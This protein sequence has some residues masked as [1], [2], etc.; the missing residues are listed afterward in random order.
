MFQLLNTGF[1]WSIH[2]HPKLNNWLLWSCSCVIVVVH[3]PKCKNMVINTWALCFEASYITVHKM[4]Q[5][6]FNGR[7]HKCVK[8]YS[9]HFL[10]DWNLRG[11]GKRNVVA[12]WQV[13][14]FTVQIWAA[15]KE[16]KVN[17]QDPGKLINESLKNILNNTHSLYNE[18]V[19]ARYF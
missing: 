7:S 9:Y 5:M 3:F 17:W 12:I 15:G 18:I 13:L 10:Q 11:E 6:D 4:L 1:H 8:D 14:L 2:F 19:K 16:P